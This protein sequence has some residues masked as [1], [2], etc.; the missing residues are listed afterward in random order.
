MI[1]IKKDHLK[2][3]R[4]LKVKA[5]CVLVF[6]FFKLKN[7]QTESFVNCFVVCF[8]IR[9]LAKS[10]EGKDLESIL[11]TCTAEMRKMCVTMK[12]RNYK[13]KK[14]STKTKKRPFLKEKVF[15]IKSCKKVLT[16]RGSVFVKV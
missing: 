15:L 14:N 4:V 12:M 1:N 8:D 2:P 6:V 5:T 10:K 3:R 13:Y 11:I 9:G 7:L 16:L